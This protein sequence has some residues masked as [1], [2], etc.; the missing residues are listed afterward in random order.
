MSN[1]VEG[2]EASFVDAP[3]AKLEVFVEG[4]TEDPVILLYGGPGVPDRLG[5]HLLGK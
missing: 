3:S 5:R 4:G 2:R 1:N